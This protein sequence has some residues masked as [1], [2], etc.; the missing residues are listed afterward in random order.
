[1]IGFTAFLTGLLFSLGLLISG[2]TMPSKVIAFL[3]VTGQWDP[4]LAF[5]MGG[6]VLVNALLFR[7]A[8][9]KEKP[10]LSSVY[11]LPTSKVIDK[12]LLVG[13]ALF[14]I[15][16]GLGGI[17]PGPG[18]VDVVAGSMQTL[19]FVGAMIAGMALF[20]MYERSRISHHHTPA[21]IHVAGH[22]AHV[23]HT[24]THVHNDE[25]KK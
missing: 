12:P 4:S 6:A 2:M 25:N 14:G 8:Q 21:P 3:D 7:V 19:A 20:R 15:G 9:K 23:N 18:L 13:A 1:M 5:V 17:C 11:H 16:W 10:V 24:E 22:H